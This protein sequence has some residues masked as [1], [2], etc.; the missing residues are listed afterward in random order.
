MGGAIARM[1]ERI[2]VYRVLVGKPG[3]HL[4]DPG[5]NGRIM[6]RWSFQEVGCWGS[7]WIELAVFCYLW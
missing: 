2:G 7:H 5:V 4:G 6:L 1:G 3:L